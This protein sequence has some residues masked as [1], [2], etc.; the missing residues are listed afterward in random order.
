[1]A[2]LHL[3]NRDHLRIGKNLWAGV[4]LVRGGGGSVL[5]D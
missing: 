2:R 4:G 5:Y 1:M 3:G